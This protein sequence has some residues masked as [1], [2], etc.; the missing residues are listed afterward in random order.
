MYLFD[1][2][3]GYVCSEVKIMTSEHNKRRKK[4]AASP[5]TGQEAQETASVVVRSVGEKGKPSVWRV[6]CFFG[7]LC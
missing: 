5:P 2:K 1:D 3:N 4:K 7:A 6:S